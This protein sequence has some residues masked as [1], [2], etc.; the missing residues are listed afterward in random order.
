MLQVIKNYKETTD[1]INKLDDAGEPVS[2][3]LSDKQENCF[4]ALG[5]AAIDV[6]NEKAGGDGVKEVKELMSLEVFAL[7]VREKSALGFIG[8]LNGATA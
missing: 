4:Q 6:L 8:I 5:L 7:A 3:E 1:L 2:F